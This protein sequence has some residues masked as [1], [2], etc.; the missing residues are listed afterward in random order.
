MSAVIEAKARV[1]PVLEVGTT[2][3]QT[4]SS[5]LFS[6]HLSGL[7]RSPLRQA[8]QRWSSSLSAQ[9]LQS[10]LQII[11]ADLVPQLLSGYSPARCSPDERLS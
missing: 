10:L 3:Q 9:D 4:P 7:A 2:D 1:E 5:G 8:K 6:G 11:E